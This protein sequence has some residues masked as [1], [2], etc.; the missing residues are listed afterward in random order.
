MMSRTNVK[1]GCKKQNRYVDAEMF[2]SKFAD[3]ILILSIILYLRDSKANFTFFAEVGY[4]WFDFQ[5]KPK[6]G[7]I[8]IFK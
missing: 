6:I 8:P 4:C 7:K 5:L 2:I 1:N 3:K